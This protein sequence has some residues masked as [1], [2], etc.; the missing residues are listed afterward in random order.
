MKSI[1]FIDTEIDPKSHEIL[2]IGGLKDNGISFHS[3]SISGIIGFLKGADYLCGH[4]IL[5]FDLNYIQAIIHDAGIN[6]SHI[7]DTLHL[8]PLLF[9]ARPYHAL[10]KDD[11]IQTGGE[12]NP[13]NDARK[14]KDLFYDEVAAFERTDSTV[15]Q[16]FYLLLQDKKEFGP[17]FKYILYDGG[18]ADAELIIRDKFRTGICEHA[19]LPRMISEHPVELAYCLAL[20]NC[21]SRHSITP[22]WILKNYPAVA[23]VMGSLRNKPCLTGCIY[24]NMTLGSA[25]GLK[26]YFGFDAFRS[27]AGEPLQEKAVKA[28]LNNKSFLAVFPTGGGKSITFQVPAFMS[29][30]AAKGLTVVISPLQSLILPEISFVRSPDRVTPTPSGSP[31]ASIL[32]A[33]HRIPCPAVAIFLGYRFPVIEKRG[34]ATLVPG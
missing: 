1:A 34:V 10:L 8:S 19:D 23:K 25:I 16:I 20:I 31:H 15:K 18:E 33:P 7:I 27:Y 12:N 26:K 22:P 5:N 11:K 24:C 28:A 9:P 2:D 3:N 6:T 17:F 14:A 29:G 32:N 30:A 13:L 21:H 4:N